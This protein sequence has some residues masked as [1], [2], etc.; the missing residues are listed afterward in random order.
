MRTLQKEAATGR[1]FFFE[2]QS[3]R[4]HHGTLV[5]E[6]VVEVCLQLEGDQLGKRPCRAMFVTCSMMVESSVFSL[7]RHHWTTPCTKPSMP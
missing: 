4:V 6:G 5:P 7:S 2:R 1:L 3:W